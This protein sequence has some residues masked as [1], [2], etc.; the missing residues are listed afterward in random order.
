MNFFVKTEKKERF[1]VLLRNPYWSKT[2]SVSV[3]NEKVNINKGYISI[4]KEW[5]NGDKI[6]INL[7]MRCEAIY[8][9]SYGCEILMNKVLDKYPLYK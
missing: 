9:I 5:E 6:E 2:T 8:P 3:N 7:D 4:E 1:E